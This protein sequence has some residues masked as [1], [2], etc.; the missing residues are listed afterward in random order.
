VHTARKNTEVFRQVFRCVPDDS[1]HTWS[2]YKRFV[3]A[4]VLACHS[5]L[6]DVPDEDIQHKLQEIRGHLVEF[7]LHFLEK[8]DL[9]NAFSVEKLVPQETFT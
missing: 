6:A 4:H 8:E 5:A 2:E 1:V 3:P 7:P 9:L